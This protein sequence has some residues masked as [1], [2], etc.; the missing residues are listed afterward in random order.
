MAEEIK[1]ELIAEVKKAASSMNEVALQVEQLNENIETFGD[2]SKEET[3]KVN[4]ED[5]KRRAR[6]RS[7]GERVERCSGPRTKIR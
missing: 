5:E 2:K 1:I 4:K 3:K 6:R 7:I